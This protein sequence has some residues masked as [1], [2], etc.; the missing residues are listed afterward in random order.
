MAY[1]VL[2]PFCCYILPNSI[3]SCAVS[4]GGTSAESGQTILTM[5]HVPWQVRDMSTYAGWQAPLRISVPFEY[6]L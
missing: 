3:I 5:A 2:M 6:M 4:V 1:A